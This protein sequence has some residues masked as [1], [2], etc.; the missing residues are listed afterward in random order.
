MRGGTRLHCVVNAAAGDETRF[1][2]AK[3][4]Q[5]E[6]IAV[7][8]AGPAGLTYASL[9][10]DT[11][12]V[13]IFERENAAGGAFRHAGKAPLFQEVAAEQTSFDRYI[14]NM[15]A[16]CMDKGVIFL[17]GV[18]VTKL[19]ER[20]ASY[21]RIVIATGARYRFALGGLPNLLLDGGAGRWPVLR[22][23]FTMRSFRDWLYHGARRSRG[24]GTRRI[25]GPR[26][27]IVVI[28]DALKPGKSR[29]A[30]ASAFEA[31][32]LSR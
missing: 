29:L 5:G 20:I 7:I 8:G 10:A 4:P 12:R 23:I 26:Q 27:K 18:D 28:G 17:Y 14:M 22:W 19:P 3:P 16:A 25:C 2:A 6:R 15:V 21:D 31:A 9:I 13:T 30:I 32:L 1:A 11:N 24:E